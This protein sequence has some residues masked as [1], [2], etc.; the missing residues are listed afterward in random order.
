MTYDTDS[1][2]EVDP[3]SNDGRGTMVLGE[4]APP[5]DKI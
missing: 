4:K 1:D 2:L 5:S 3:V